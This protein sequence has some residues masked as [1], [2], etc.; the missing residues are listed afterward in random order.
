MEPTEDSWRALARSSPWRWRTAHFTR[1]DDEGTV[2]AWVRRPGELLVRDGSGRTT[3]EHG[4]PYTTSTVVASAADDGSEVPEPPRSRLPHE[5]VPALR[6]DGLVAHR[7]DRVLVD[8]DDPMY[9]DFTWVAML[10]PVELSEGTLVE[11]VRADRVAG[12]GVWR[13]VVRAGEGYDPR[14]PCCPLLWS[15]VS[16][17]EEY[18]ERGNPHV[19]TADYPEAYDVALDVGTGV[20]VSLQPLGG[21]RDD[22]AF[23]VDL[24]AVDAPVDEVFAGR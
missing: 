20:V 12:R 11:R 19:D 21:R 9:G 16:D 4:L 8:Y 6:P 10:D 23:T 13:A 17:E 1:T 24:L 18:G 2:E 5:V 14:C 3:Y 22:L 15:V 7:P